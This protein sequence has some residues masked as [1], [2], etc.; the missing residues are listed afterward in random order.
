MVQAMIKI[1]NQ[2]NQILNIV[3]AKNN[4]ND[5]SEAIELVIK[6]YGKDIMEPQ[7]RPEFIEKMK[8][9][10]KESTIEIKDFKKHFGLN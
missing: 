6:E 5:K 1:S 3:K 7:L 8:R 9:R 4:L 10:E 2:A